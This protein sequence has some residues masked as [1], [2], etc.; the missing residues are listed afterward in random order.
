MHGAGINHRLF[1]QMDSDAV[2]ICG[3]AKLDG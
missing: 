1:A 3:P 2:L